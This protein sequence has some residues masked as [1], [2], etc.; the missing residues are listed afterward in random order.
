[1]TISKLPIPSRRGFLCQAG[2]F[3]LNAASW[4]AFG[5]VKARAPLNFI[6]YRN[7][8]RLGFHRI[9]FSEDGER[10][11]VDIE[12]AFDVKLA[13]IPLYRYRHRNYEVWEDGRLVSLKSETDDNGDAF[14]VRVNRQGDRLMVDGVDGKLEVPGNTLSTS[15]WNEAAMNSGVWL[16]TQ[17]GKLVRSEVT[18]KSAEPVMVGGASV[19]AMPYELVG[20]ISCTLWY[21]DGRWVK[22]RFI[23]EDDSVIEYT[24]ETVG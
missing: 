16:D 24:L 22:L 2:L 21:H 1:M 19:A 13:F 14:K 3:G 5:A 4:P 6:A 15:Y 18:K 8:S 7:G 9:D 12:I 10:L 20:D 11:T 23:G 17:E